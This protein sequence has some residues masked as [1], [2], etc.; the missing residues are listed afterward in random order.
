[1]KEIIAIIRREKVI[2]VKEV[3]SQKGIRFVITNVR[4]RGK[5]GGLAYKGKKGVFMSLLPK[6]LLFTWVEDDRDEEVLQTIMSLAW[7]GHYGDGKIFVIH[8]IT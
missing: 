4:G 8:H 2:N 1:M 7:T 6:V 3:L 5:E